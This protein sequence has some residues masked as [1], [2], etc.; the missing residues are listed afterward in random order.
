MPDDNRQ[1]VNSQELSAE[2]QF[3]QQALDYHAY[4]T[5]GKI[6]VE[7]TKPANSAEDLALAYSLVLQSQ[8]VKLRRMWITST[9]TRQKAIRSRLYLTVLRFL[10]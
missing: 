10:V 3:R 2:E 1:D 9:S 4:P 7:V 6:A 8:S 5:P